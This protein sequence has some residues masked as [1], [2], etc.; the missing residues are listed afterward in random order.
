VAALV[1]IP[2]L[3]AIAAGDGDPLNIVGAIVFSAS[4]VA[5]YFS[6][7]VYHPRLSQW[8]SQARL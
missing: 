3:V 4:V 6:S 5:L 8:Q 7:T 1:G 2:F